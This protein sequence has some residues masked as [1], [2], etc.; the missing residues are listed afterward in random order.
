MFFSHGTTISSSTAPK[1][2]VNDEINK[3]TSIT[4]IFN[5][6]IYVKG[7]MTAFSGIGYYQIQ[8]GKFF[9]FD[10]NTTIGDIRFKNRRTRR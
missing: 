2:V 10:G 5:C 1:I 7:N 3:T 9:Y 6:D 8:S 4:N